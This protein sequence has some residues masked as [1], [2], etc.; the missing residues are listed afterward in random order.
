MTVMTACVSDDRRWS[1]RC[2]TPNLV[3]FSG[4]KCSEPLGCVTGSTF[5]VAVPA[6]DRRH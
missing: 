2:V 1:H 3:N 5:S 6:K 4:K